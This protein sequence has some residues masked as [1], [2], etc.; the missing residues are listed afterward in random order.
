MQRILF[1]LYY[2]KLRVTVLLGIHQT[3]NPLDMKWRWN[4]WRVRRAAR[5]TIKS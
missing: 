4:Y 5:T 1:L 2:L 3:S